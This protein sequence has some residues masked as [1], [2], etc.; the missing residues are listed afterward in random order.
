MNNT[1]NDMLKDEH[2]MWKIIV[3]V[4]YIKRQNTKFNLLHI[5]EY[6]VTYIHKFISITLCTHVYIHDYTHIHHQLVCSVFYSLCGTCSFGST[7][8]IRR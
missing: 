6:A 8:L 4:F 1:K 7:K 3:L 5:Y 2:L